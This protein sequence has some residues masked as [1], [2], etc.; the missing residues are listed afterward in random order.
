[1]GDNLATDDMCVTRDEMGV[2]EPTLGNGLTGSP[3][4]C[5]S[6]EDE[7]ERRTLSDAS[8]SGENGGA[9]RGNRA[10]PELEPGH[11]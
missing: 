11:F 8:Q 5:D 2:S 10:F 7:Q 1:V 9:R 6:R 4:L 3:G